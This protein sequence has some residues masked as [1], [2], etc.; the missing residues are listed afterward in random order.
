[1]FLGLVVTAV[2]SIGGSV[3]PFLQLLYSAIFPSGGDSVSWPEMGDREDQ[4]LGRWIPMTWVAV[5]CGAPLLWE[6]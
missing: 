5:S 4:C 6:D 2:G 3:G 1:M